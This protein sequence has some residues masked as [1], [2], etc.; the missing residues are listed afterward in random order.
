MSPNQMSLE[1]LELHLISCIE[2]HSAKLCRDLT[3]KKFC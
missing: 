3:D 2:S 1:I